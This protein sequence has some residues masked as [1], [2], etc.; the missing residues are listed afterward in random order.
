MKSPL[1]TDC[2]L[3][4]SNSL[5]TRVEGYQDWEEGA[6]ERYRKHEEDLLERGKDML[7]RET[8]CEHKLLAAEQLFDYVKKARTEASLEGS[9]IQGAS[10]SSWIQADADWQI[11]CDGSS[12]DNLQGREDGHASLAVIFRESSTQTVSE[13]L[14]TVAP[15]TPIPSTPLADRS[16]DFTPADVKHR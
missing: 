9:G 15:A 11:F 8:E 13:L 6:F 5:A 7:A 12:C 16:C 2:V 14:E 4:V 3:L 10:G 1:Q